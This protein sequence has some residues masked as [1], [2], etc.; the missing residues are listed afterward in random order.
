MTEI[1]EKA[2]KTL[3]ELVKQNADVHNEFA[4][5]LDPSW[6]PSWQSYMVPSNK[7]KL[8]KEGEQM[9]TAMIMMTHNSTESLCN[10]VSH[11]FDNSKEVKEIC[12][13]YKVYALVL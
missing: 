7:S 12:K 13:K 5:M 6:E 2:M 4:K 8:D 3:D 11:L 9:A 10:Y 1:K